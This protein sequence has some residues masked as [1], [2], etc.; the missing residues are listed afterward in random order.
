M[1]SCSFTVDTRE[2]PGILNPKTVYTLTPHKHEKKTLHGSQ[3][4]SSMEVN[5]RASKFPPQVSAY[6]H[7]PF[8]LF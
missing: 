6:S 8:R 2:I 3:A 1:N 4:E 7:W 5:V